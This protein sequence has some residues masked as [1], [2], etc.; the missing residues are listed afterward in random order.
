M[1]LKTSIKFVCT[2]KIILYFLNPNKYI[3]ILTSKFLYKKCDLFGAKTKFYEWR[4]CFNQ[5]SPSGRDK[6]HVWYSWWTII[7]YVRCCLSIGSGKRHRDCF[8]SA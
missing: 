4:R 2:N 5:M 1:C 3:I 6:I 8:I 7:K